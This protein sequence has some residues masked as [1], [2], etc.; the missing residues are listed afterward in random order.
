MIAVA[1]SPNRA[2]ARFQE[3]NGFHDDGENDQEHDRFNERESARG[4]FACFLATEGAADVVA[5]EHFAIPSV[6]ANQGATP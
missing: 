3:E 5:K 6:V 1:V 4:A 2:N